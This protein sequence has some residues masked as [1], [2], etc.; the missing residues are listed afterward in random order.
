MRVLS[1]DAKRESQYSIITTRNLFDKENDS[2]MISPNSGGQKR[3]V[4]VD[5]NVYKF[6]QDA[7]KNY[8]KEKSIEAKIVAFHCDESKKSIDSFLHMFKEVDEFGLNRR[9]EPLIAI[10]GGVLTDMAGFV[11]STYRR[12]IPHIK[13]PTTLMGYV[14][15]SVGIKTGVNFEKGKNRMGTFEP[16]LA[17]LLDKTF[18][19][20]QETRDIINGVGEIIK[21]AIIK[22]IHLLE[23]LENI[24]ERSI[25]SKFQEA[26]E[27]ILDRS[28]EMMIE[29][30][31]PNLY[32]TNLS[33]AVDFG[34][35]F[36]LALEMQEIHNLKHGEAVA[37]DVAFSVLLSHIRHFLCDAD[38]ERVIS[39][40]KKLKIP[41]K[42][43]AIDADLFWDSVLERKMHRDGHQRIPLPSPLGQC[44]FID[45]L[46][47]Q[48][49]QNACRIIKEL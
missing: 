2:L 44:V 9:N 35:T 1:V 41:Y 20:T 10:G 47:K 21:I 28:I 46:T 5:Q 11:A 31:E 38:A 29:E 18:L 25:H 14:D 22:D 49:V 16:P 17:V 42:H 12:G 30:L 45:D 36:S 33:R 24:G 7:I 39:L 19:K 43:E 8:F 15:A 40:M 13:V 48:E 4:A 34:H 6:H 23:L 27:E 3:F 32:E 37:I 26:G